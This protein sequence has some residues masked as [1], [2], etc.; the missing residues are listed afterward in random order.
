MSLVSMSPLERARKNEQVILQALAATGQNTV[1]LAMGVNEST[2]SRLKDGA[3]GQ[4]A[5]VLAHC[6][7]KVVPAGMACFDPAY[8]E[9]LKTLAEVGI[10]QQ[11]PKLDWSESA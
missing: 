5:A 1:A 10:R 9:A 7:L 3:L 2:V 6:G 4:A 8:V 11:A